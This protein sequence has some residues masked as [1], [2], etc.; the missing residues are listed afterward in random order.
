MNHEHLMERLRAAIRLPGNL[1]KSCKFFCRGLDIRVTEIHYN[2]LSDRTS[3]RE[4]KAMLRENLSNSNIQ[5][6]NNVRS[7]INKILDQSLDSI[8]ISDRTVGIIKIKIKDITYGKSL[9][10]KKN[11]R[12]I[13]K[14][15]SKEHNLIIGDYFLKQEIRQQLIND[16]LL[17]QQK[18]YIINKYSAAEIFL[19]VSLTKPTPFPG[20]YNGC[21]AIAAGFHFY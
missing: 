7:R 18:K 4:D 14:D 19:T 10:G 11:F 15:S 1:Q 17:Q 2:S 8:F 3:R 12:M 9:G 20:P 16:E 6:D 13:F 5:R 21:H